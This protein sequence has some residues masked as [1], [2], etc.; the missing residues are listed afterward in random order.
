[1]CL[2]TAVDKKSTFLVHIFLLIQVK[3]SNQ[4]SGAALRDEGHQRL[5]HGTLAV[6]V[7][8]GSRSQAQQ[9]T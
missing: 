9:T 5:T 2:L 4:E 3:G 1:M 7:Q 8:E 6:G